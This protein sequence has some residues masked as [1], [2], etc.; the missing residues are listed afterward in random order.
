MSLRVWTLALACAAIS[1]P[2][3]AET[4]SKTLDNGLKVIVREDA[5]AP[6]VVT[7]LWYKVGSVDEQAGKTGLSHVLEHMMFKGTPSVPSGEYSKRITAMGGELNAYT[8]RDETVYY[9]TV[10]KQHLPEVL[11]MEA[12]RMV[13]LGFSNKDYVNELE[14][15]KEERR[16]RTDDSPSGRLYEKLY[17]TAFNTSGN[18]SPIIGSMD[19]LTHM[20]GDDARAWYQRWYAPNN[21]TM[22]IVGDV[23]AKQAIDQVERAFGGLKPSK[24]PSRA[25]PAEPKQTQE[26]SA[27][28][29]APS[30]LPIVALGYQVPQLKQL[31]DKLPYALDTLADVL[32]G[33]AAS[34]MEKNLV[35][36]KPI[37]LSAG[38]SY[39][40]LTRADTLFVL[41][42][43]P[44]QGVS[45]PQ[46][47]AALKGE[48]ADIAKN[49]VSEEELARIRNQREAS[50][51]YAK[52]SMSTQA[53]LMGDLESKGFSYQNEDEVRRR[54][55][56]VTA[57]EVQQ[58]AQFLSDETV[59]QVILKP[60]ALNQKGSK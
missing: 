58:A 31:D 50:E 33:N 8:N 21:A 14:V 12:D 3:F 29:S 55:N 38:A 19:D 11:Q 59:T 54:L 56:A 2:V 15:V 4:L 40:L 37:A 47:I 45:V 18:K 13:N 48:V 44:A 26:R 20:T 17:Q 41:S 25:L 32:D 10:A 9:Q 35:R 42:G 16:L 43:A 49:G 46:L 52:D 39:S 36:A 6:V 1:A 60:E 23:N 57:A 7:Q 53:S 30:E 51:T 22:I 27:E 24:L 28:V 5:R 34:R